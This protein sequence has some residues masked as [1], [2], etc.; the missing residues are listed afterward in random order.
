MP[1]EIL[2]WHRLELDVPIRTQMIRKIMELA[3]YY[4]SNLT[5]DFIQRL[6]DLAKKVEM[7]LYVEAV[8]MR[9]Y[10]DLKTLKRRIKAISNS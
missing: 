1:S 8:S 7:V 3:L 9:T 2:T 10:A 6:P 5:D 4:N